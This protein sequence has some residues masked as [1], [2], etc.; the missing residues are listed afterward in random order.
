[1]MV[2]SG[3]LQPLAALPLSHS[4]FLSLFTVS[5]NKASK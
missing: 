4:A 5:V 2:K 1:M 3:E